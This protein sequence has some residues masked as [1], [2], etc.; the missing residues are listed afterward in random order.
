MAPTEQCKSTNP[1]FAATPEQSPLWNRVRLLEHQLE[2]CGQ[3]LHAADETKAVTDGKLDRAR[4]E[5]TMLCQ[6][7]AKVEKLGCVERRLDAQVK[8]IDDLERKRPSLDVVLSWAS[9]MHHELQPAMER[10]NAL[11]AKARSE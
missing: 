11:E 6:E 3:E 4:D 7:R 10:I 9:R 2:Q 1:A 8:R 5:L